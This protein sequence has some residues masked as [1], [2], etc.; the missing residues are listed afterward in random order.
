MHPSTHC[1]ALWDSISLPQGHL[2]TSRTGPSSQVGLG[3]CAATL[4]AVE[5]V[6]AHAVLRD[7][8]AP[9]EEIFAEGV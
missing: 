5:P 1:T 4:L 7:Q 6:A 2:L 8:I 9:V 3:A